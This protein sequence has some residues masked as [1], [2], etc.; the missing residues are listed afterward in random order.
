MGCD[1]HIRAERKVGD[2]W[3]II[4]GL[5]P[6]DWRQYGM[7]GFLAD[8]RNYSAIP[9]ISPA[10][11]LPDDADKRGYLGDHS[12]SWLSVSELSSFDYD[13]PIEDRR[14]MRNGNGGTTAEPGGGRMTTYREFLGKAFFDDLAELVDAGADRIV[15][16]FDC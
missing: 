7:F 8:V 13:R 16:G 4:D 11:G 14:V 1:I 12:Y 15:F 6:F 5:K 2:K 3:E 9:P 10:R